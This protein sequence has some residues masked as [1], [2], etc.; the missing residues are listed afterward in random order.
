MI[1]HK[2]DLDKSFQ[3]VLYR[4]DNWINEGSGWLVQKIHSQYINIS[5]FRPLSGSSYIK[6]LAE[7]Q[8]P[9]KRLISIKSN[10]QKCFLWYHIRHLNPLKIHPERITKQDKEL[11]NTL[12][13]EI[14]EFLVSKKDFDKI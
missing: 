11:T 7:L 3:E 12:D 13:Y 8:N 2:F 4:I 5:T 6:L 1:N 14:I 9:K 10:D